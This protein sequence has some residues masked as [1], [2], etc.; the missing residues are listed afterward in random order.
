[1]RRYPQVL[2]NVRVKNKN[3][4]EKNQAIKDIIAKYTE[5]LGDNGQI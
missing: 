3:G 5:E 4:W 2:V 1:M